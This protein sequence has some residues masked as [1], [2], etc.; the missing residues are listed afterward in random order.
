MDLER[1]VVFANVDLCLEALDGFAMARSS[2]W[3][4]LLLRVENE[5]TVSQK[6]SSG[7]S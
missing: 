2:P 3:G 1:R 6:E 4:F 5:S 7:R